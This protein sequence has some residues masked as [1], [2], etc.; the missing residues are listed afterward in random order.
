MKL[1]SLFAMVCLFWIPFAYTQDTVPKAD[2]HSQRLI[3][4]QRADSLRQALKQKPGTSDVLNEFYAD[5]YRRSVAKLMGGLTSIA[6]GIIILTVKDTK[7]AGDYIGSSD[8]SLVGGI[9]L[10]VGGGVLSIYQA[11]KLVL[12]R[13][14]PRKPLLEVRTTGTG[15]GFYYALN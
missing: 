3:R 15:I 6:G 11:N 1:L 8:L 9:G 10:I 7:L 14:A 5:E 4:Q 12:M 2:T 13:S